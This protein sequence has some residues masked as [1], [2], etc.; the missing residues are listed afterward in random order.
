MAMR[1]RA[2]RAKAL[3]ATPRAKARLS[4]DYLNRYGEALMLLELAAMDSEI[5]GDLAQW[6]AVGYREHFENSQLRC[7]AEAIEAYGDLDAAHRT[8]FDELCRAMNRLI[9]S[10]SALLRDLSPGPHLD[11][12]VAAA[13]ESLR[14]LIARATQFIN[15][16][17]DLD[18][19]EIHS[20]NLQA[21]IDGL[22]AS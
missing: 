9:L 5:A 20:R 2:G 12:V 19:G 14:E 17:G 21:E 4:T 10:A 22:F 15:A 13:S 3:A 7:A 1:A 11:A 6:K 8:G 18:L 16:N